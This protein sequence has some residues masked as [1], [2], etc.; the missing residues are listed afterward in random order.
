MPV[1]GRVTANNGQALTQAA[2]AG[3]GIHIAPEFIVAAAV[4]AGDL[5]PILTDWGA[6]SLD[7]WTVYPHRRF[8]P[9]KVRL[10]VDFLADAFAGEVPWTL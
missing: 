10:F 2:C 4:R 1:Q 6:P 3:L 9:R 8:L 5:Q 7:L